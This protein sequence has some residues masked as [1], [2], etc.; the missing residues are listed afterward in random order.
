QQPGTLKYQNVLVLQFLQVNIFKLLDIMVP[1]SVTANELH[2]KESFEEYCESRMFACFSIRLLP[3]RQKQLDLPGHFA[4]FLGVDAYGFGAW[5]LDS[6]EPTRPIRRSSEYMQRHFQEVD[7]LACKASAFSKMDYS[8]LGQPSKFEEPVDIRQYLQSNIDLTDG[9]NPAMWQEVQRFIRR[10]R[11]FLHRRG[12]LSSAEIAERVP[13]ALLDFDRRY[14][15]WV[16]LKRFAAGEGRRCVQFYKNQG[17][18]FV[19]DTL[20][21][22]DAAL[23]ELAQKAS[24]ELAG[25]TLGNF[26]QRSSCDVEVDIFRV[27]FDGINAL[28]AA[29]WRGEKEAVKKLNNRDV[30]A[31][32]VRNILANHQWGK[33]TDSS[34]RE[35]LKA[36]AEYRY[37]GAM[38]LSKNP[39]SEEGST[40]RFHP[41]LAELEAELTERLKTASGDDREILLSLS[42]YIEHCD[43]TKV[44]R[45]APMA[46]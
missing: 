22:T 27:D 24:S 17:S 4:Q 36:Y 19:I 20:K 46:A 12:D 14:S 15:L 11:R 29:L 5:I 32:Y 13:M 8:I 23:D 35:K 31:L 44:L 10:R 7:V 18:S 40:T 30:T 33:D 43:I 41:T 34:I 16:N 25:V 3:H 26:F 9:A 42:A 21:G 6:S 2:Q 28:S 38:Q 45:G 39:A 37:G 1:R